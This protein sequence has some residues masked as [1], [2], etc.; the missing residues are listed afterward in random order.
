MAIKVVST[1]PLPEAL[2][3]EF[4]AIVPDLL[5]V[6]AGQTI[7]SG[8]TVNDEAWMRELPGFLRQ[9]ADADIVFGSFGGSTEPATAAIEARLRVCD[10]NGGLF[11]QMMRAAGNRI[12]WIHCGA[13]GVEKMICPEFVSSNVVLTS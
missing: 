11:R 2:L 7:S 1:Y 13:A 10:G 6:G 5:Y 3:A 9:V 8:E 12:R 4:K